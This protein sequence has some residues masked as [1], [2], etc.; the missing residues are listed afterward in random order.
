[1]PHDNRP[2]GIVI[3]GTQSGCGKTSVSLGLMA[4][5]RRRGL[6]VQPFKVGPDFIDPGHHEAVTGRTSHNLDGWMLGRDTVR[7]IFGRYAAGADVVVVEGVMGLFDG[8]S[9]TGETGSTA[10]IAKWLGLPVLLVVDARSMARS[11]A[12]LVGGFLSF[13]PGLAFA[14]VAMNKVGSAGHRDILAEAASALPVPVLGYLG[15]EDGIMTPSRHLGLVTAQDH[16]WEEHALGRL[17]AWIE[18]GLDL[19]GLLA[20][21]PALDLSGLQPAP[22]PARIVRRARIGLARDRAFCFYYAE[23]LRLLEQAGAELVPFSPMAD[24]HLPPGLDGL[25]LGGGYP[26]LHGPALA[27][28]ASMR[29]DVKRFAYSGRPVHAECGGFM[30]LLRAIEAGG[31]AAYP[32]AG[33]FNRTCRMADRLQALGYREVATTLPTLLGPA[34]T[35]LRGHEFHYSALE[36]AD[37]EARQA[38]AATD[39][40]GRPAAAEGLLRADALGSYVHLHLG[41]NPAVARHFV[42]RCVAARKR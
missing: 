40:N 20:S 41:S 34:G 11:A 8:A 24:P 9:G 16:A 22:P 33:V 4:A 6:S 5:L 10:E 15:R 17:S 35:V 1:M 25:Y 37:P 13:D 14:G 38:Y 39:R 31:G 21:L 32:M 42:D 18:T 28:N 19:D 36:G 12:A 3:A 26:E 30:Y 2:K 23:S 7:G 27:D 29:V